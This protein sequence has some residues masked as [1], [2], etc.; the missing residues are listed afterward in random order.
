VIS[1]NE[2]KKEIALNECGLSEGSDIISQGVPYQMDLV[3]VCGNGT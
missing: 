3:T 1:G 2:Y